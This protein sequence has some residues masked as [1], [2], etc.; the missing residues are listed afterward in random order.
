MSW[1][2]PREGCHEA[3]HCYV[4]RRPCGHW[5]SVVV[6]APAQPEMVGDE[7]RAMV[8][9]GCRVERMTIAEFRAWHAREYCS[10]ESP[11]CTGPR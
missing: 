6:D 1:A 2:G 4:G 8:Q 9:D 11:P 3:T 10:C 5:L 7:V